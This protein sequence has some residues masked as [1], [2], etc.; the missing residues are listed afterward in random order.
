MSLRAEAVAERQ[1]PEWSLSPFEI[2]E[3]GKLGD[4]R[5]LSG[6]RDKRYTWARRA[7]E[8]TKV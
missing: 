1:L 8:G 4:R 2:R 3:L 6:W 7:A 5:E